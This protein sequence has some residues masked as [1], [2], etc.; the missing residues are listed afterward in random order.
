MRGPIYFSRTLKTAIQP[1]CF[2]RVLAS[3]CAFPC[4]LAIYDDSATKVQ[5]DFGAQ[6]HSY[7]IKP[8]DAPSFPYPR[9]Q[10]AVD[11]N[12]NVY[13][14]LRPCSFLFLL[15]LNDA[16]IYARKPVRM[17][18]A[19]KWLTRLTGIS[20]VSGTMLLHSSPLKWSA[21]DSYGSV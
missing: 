15:C 12:L 17:G 6:K 1:A 14:H 10:P 8:P 2:L 5:A 13:A 20:T 19:E 21:R 7:F 3:A 18:K 11:V 9:P 4:Y 16:N